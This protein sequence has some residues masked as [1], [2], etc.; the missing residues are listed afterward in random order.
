MRKSGKV[1]PTDL[2]TL[3][4]LEQAIEFS[5]ADVSQKHAYNAC[6]TSMDE[7]KEIWLSYLV[8]DHWNQTGF[9]WS[10]AEFLNTGDRK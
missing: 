7:K 5:D 2:T 8:K 6:T 3:F 9:D 10:S 4:E 1:S